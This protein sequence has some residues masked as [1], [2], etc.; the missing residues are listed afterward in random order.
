G[1]AQT[2][3]DARDPARFRG[4]VEPIDPVAG[5]IPG[6]RCAPSS[7]N[8]DE[9]GFFKSKAALRERFGALLAEPQDRPVVCYCGSGLTAAHNILALRHAGFD[10]PALYAGSW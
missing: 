4:E 7:G 8:L 2:L 9:R 6:A 1:D 5:H 3:L 10:E